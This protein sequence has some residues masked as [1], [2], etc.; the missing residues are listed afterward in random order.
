MMKQDTNNEMCGNPGPNRTLHLVS[1]H[2]ALSSLLCRPNTT[3]QVAGE[4][5]TLLSRDLDHPLG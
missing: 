1:I 4:L 3:T 2:G 5:F